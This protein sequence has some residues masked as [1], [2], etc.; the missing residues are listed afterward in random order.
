MFDI[1][2]SISKWFRARIWQSAKFFA[3]S[4]LLLPIIT[5]FIDFKLDSFNNQILIEQNRVNNLAL[6][7]SATENHLMQIR[8][9]KLFR[10]VLDPNDLIIKYHSNSSFITKGKLDQIAKDFQAGKISPEEYN[11]EL[12]KSYSEENEIA[13]RVYDLA[14]DYLNSRRGNDFWWHISKYFVMLLSIACALRIPFLAPKSTIP[15]TKKI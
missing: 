11:N 9:F 1:L 5:G 15:M 2:N 12:I 13:S 8:F 3:T 6:A 14:V 4:L 10:I 7:K